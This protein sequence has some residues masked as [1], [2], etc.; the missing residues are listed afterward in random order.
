MGG[1]DSLYDKIDK[2]IR[3]CKVVLTCVTSKYALSANCR[4]EVSLADALK[5]PVIPLLLEK[6]TWPPDGPMSMVFTQLLYINFHSPD[7]NIQNT[8][9]CPQLNELIATLQTHIPHRNDTGPT[10]QNPEKTMKAMKRNSIENK[11]STKK[12]TEVEKSDQAVPAPSVKEIS[13]E[14]IETEETSVENKNIKCKEEKQEEDQTVQRQTGITKLEE[15]SVLNEYTRK[16][17]ERDSR[18]QGQKPETRYPTN[19]LFDGDMPKQRAEK[20]STCHII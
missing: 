10:P 15:T 4:R 9:D 19:A 11:K 2:G 16:K 18:V 13:S 8:W 20:S 1:G 7:I 3:S 5:K 12:T 14:S 17:E 6:M